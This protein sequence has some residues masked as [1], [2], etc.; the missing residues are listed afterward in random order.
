MFRILGFFVGNNCSYVA[1][2]EARK[3]MR[4]ASHNKIANVRKTPVE[5]GCIEVRGKLFA[6]QN[7]LQLLKFDKKKLCLEFKKAEFF[8]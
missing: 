3:A 1:L 5:K 4:C 8:H 7:E 6:I 2:N